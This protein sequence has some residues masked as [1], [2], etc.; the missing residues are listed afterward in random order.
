MP[1]LSRKQRPLVHDIVAGIIRRAGVPAGGI[2]RLSQPPTLQEK[3][4]GPRL[5]R[6]PIVIMPRKCATVDERLARYLGDI[7]QR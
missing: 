7:G 4:A 1:S 6:R 3:A 2:V 5:E